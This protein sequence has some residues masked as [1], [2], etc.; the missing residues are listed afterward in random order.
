MMRPNELECLYLAI[1]FQ[2]SLAF[3]GNT[4]S[5]P[6]NEASERSS[7]WVGP[8]PAL[9]ER[10]SKGEPSSFLGLVVS[11]EGQKFYNIDT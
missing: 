7:N 8:G 3:P 6:E 11:D 2:S 1:T 10:V 5:L 9:M 4:R